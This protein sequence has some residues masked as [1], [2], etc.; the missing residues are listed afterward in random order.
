[1]EKKKPNV[2]TANNNQ[3]EGFYVG[4]NFNASE[5]A[6]II[7]STD[8][9]IDYNKSTDLD[10][11][12]LAELFTLLNSHIDASTRPNSDKKDAKEAAQ[13]LADEVKQVKKDPKHKPDKFRMN[14]LKEAF[15]KLGA[16]VFNAAMKILG[17]PAL[18]Q[19]VNEFAENLSED[20]K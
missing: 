6:I 16:P 7:N 2:P 9:S 3:K 14:G 18:G 10:K 17:Y 12:N 19:A 13:L 4:G 1:M 20:N 5:S 11:K 15:R 8:T